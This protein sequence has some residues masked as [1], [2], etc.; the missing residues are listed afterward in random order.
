MQEVTC[1]LQRT[2]N[3]ILAQNP[4]SLKWASAR[5]W[6]FG[7]ILAHK[8]RVMPDRS[9]N[10]LEGN[11][12]NSDKLLFFTQHYRAESQSVY[13]F[14]N[15]ELRL[16]LHLE[17]GKRP[18]SKF[19]ATLDLNFVKNEDEENEARLCYG[20]IRLTG[21]RGKSWRID[22]YLDC[23]DEDLYKEL[24]ERFY[25]LFNPEWFK[26]DVFEGE[27][28]RDKHCEATVRGKIPSAEVR[29]LFRDMVEYFIAK[30]EPK[31][32]A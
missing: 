5:Y 30:H 1:D 18:T 21:Q 28:V 11:G 19:M 22:V 7:E 20:Y 3:V 23:R 10:G 25:D 17:D 6:E 14:P 4:H 26:E 32:L 8:H 31:K 29:D 12:W 9:A 27:V 13:Y 15:V 16:S 2:A 24:C